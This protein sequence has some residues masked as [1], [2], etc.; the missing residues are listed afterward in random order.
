MLNTRVH[1]L[2]DTN[3]RYYP[4]VK[5]GVVVVM[6]KK[7]RKAKVREN[8]RELAKACKESGLSVYKW[9]KENQ[10]PST[11]C[12]KWLERLETEEANIGTQKDEKG[13]WGKIELT[14]AKTI[15]DQQPVLSES[16]IRINY[17]QWSIDISASF[18]DALLSRI[19]KV[20]ESQC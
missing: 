15:C 11:T 12:R 13:I 10:I 9:C 1:L 7:G 14:E 18:D 19:M 17:G 3:M 8:W 6:A 20:V 2:V 16:S 5:M 4:Q